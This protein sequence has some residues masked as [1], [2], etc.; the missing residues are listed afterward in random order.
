MYNLMN[1]LAE[2][3]VHLSNAYTFR[4]RFIE[5]LWLSISTKVLELSYNAKRHDIQ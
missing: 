5:A 2:Q 4:W 3:I 1:K